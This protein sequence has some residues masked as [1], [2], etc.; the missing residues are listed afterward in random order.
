[1]QA[2][3]WGIIGCGNVTEV[4]SGPA[5]NLVGDAELTAVMRRDGAKARDYALRH[6]VPKWYDDAMKLINDPD[7]NAIYIATPP[8]SHADYAIACLEK[9]K[10]VYLEKPMA[11]NKQQAARIVSAANHYQGRITIAHYRRAQAM[12]LAIGELL[13][14]KA[15]GEIRFVNLKMLQPPGSDITASSET[16]WRI[17]PPVSGG[18]LFHDLAPH[19]LDLMVHYFGKPSRANGFA[20]NQGGLYRADDLVTGEILFGK[21][22]PVFQGTW[23]FSVSPDD[24]IDICEIIGSKGKI[25]FPVFGNHVI[26]IQNGRSRELVFPPLEHVQQPMIEKVCAYFLGRGPNPCPPEQA[27]ISMELMDAFTGN[28]HR[29]VH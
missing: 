27:I 10:P 2:L 8:S 22:G 19:Q 12:F 28:A 4:K 26:V 25:S 5:F 18:G 20:L 13:Q 23:C 11:M 15:I 3:R 21:D 29:T 17:D 24:Q 6:G 7:I 16:N 9:G 1:M 14:D